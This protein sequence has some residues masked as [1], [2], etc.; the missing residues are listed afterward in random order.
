MN[1]DTFNECKKINELLVKN[2]EDKARDKLICLLDRE[3]LLDKD[4]EYNPLINHLIR[5]V[6][7]YPYL[8]S[9]N[10]LWQDRFVHGAFKVNVGE[11]KKVTF[12][13]EQSAVLKSLLE[14]TDLALIAPTS[15]G[16]SFIVDAFIK[17]K[18][19]KNVVIIVPTIALADETRRRL[20]KKF[21]TQYKIITTSNVDVDQKNIFIF[22]QERA[23]EYVGKITEVDIL[24][25][26]EF[27]KASVAFDEGRSTA[28]LNAILKFSKKSNQ[29]YFLAPN[30]SKIKR[31]PITKGMK[32]EKIIFNTVFLRKYDCYKTI[33][34]DDDKKKKLLD[35]INNTTEKTLIYAGTFTKITEVSNLLKEIN[36]SKNQTLNNFSDW[37]EKNYT[38]KWNLV[39]LVKRG[40]GIHNG[41][42]HRSLSQI[43]INLFSK[44]D[45]LKNI[46]STSSIIE[47]INTS[48]KNVVFYHN[49]NGNSKLNYF[50][51]KNLIGRSGR[52]LKHF[53]GEVY[54]LDSPPADEPVSLP[55]DIPKELINDETDDLL[56]V[57]H[58]VRK[59]VA[60]FHVEM[61]EL[62]GKV[63]YHTLRKDDFFEYYNW[64]KIKLIA[65]SMKENPNSWNGIVFLND[66]NPLNWKSSLL[67]ILIVSKFSGEKY[68]ELIE[69][70]Q[71]LSRNWDLTI[72]ELLEYIILLK[73]DINTFFEFERTV[74]FNL[75]HTL[76]CVNELQKNMLPTLKFDIS[77]FIF[78]TSHAFL[79][80]NVYLLEEYGLPRMISKKIQLSGLIDLENTEQDLHSIIRTF[81][82]ICC[83][84]IIDE[85]DDLLDFDKYILEYFFDG[86]S[87]NTILDA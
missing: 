43:Q 17:I 25:I 59:E 7:L 20:Y 52:M 65:T 28:L 63:T 2:K 5:Q 45:G 34:N 46:I 36:V 73:I 53:I 71:T 55:L 12:H 61:L 6:G 16:K 69:F 14:G 10:A 26:D 21:A 56:T 86:I 18:N 83:D 50:G 64:K 27:Y 85:V 57:S 81:N 8:K 29:R 76:N 22:P 23:L 37:L 75:S 66:S 78:K 39:E 79:P 62:L 44:D 32:V 3:R 41:K 49:K 70:T 72:E 42:L 87:S 60:D 77:P 11:A 40:T 30:I 31:N 38:K 84:R 33:E 68:R 51:Y 13:R 1:D 47:G 58:D 35:I 19:P 82:D 67:N 48:A 15:F 74:T 9:D 4:T 54:L 80:K 24:V